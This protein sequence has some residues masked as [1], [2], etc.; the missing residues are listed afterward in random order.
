MALTFWLCGRL[1]DSKHLH[2]RRPR[3]VELSA[4]TVLVVAHPE[5][6][7]SVV[8]HHAATRLAEVGG[9]LTTARS[10]V[11]DEQPP[12]LRGRSPKGHVHSKPAVRRLHG[13]FP[14]SKRDHAIAGEAR[15]H[16]VPRRDP[17]LQ[18]H[19][20]QAAGRVC[21]A[22]HRVVRVSV[23]RIGRVT[24]DRVLGQAGL[25]VDDVAVT[26]SPTDHPPSGATRRDLLLRGLATTP[27]RTAL[28]PDR[29]GGKDATATMATRHLM[30]TSIRVAVPRLDPDRRA[31][32][33]SLGPRGERTVLGS[34]AAHLL[35]GGGAAT[36]L[37]QQLG[38]AEL[39]STPIHARALSARQRDGDGVGPRSF[40]ECR[41]SADRFHRRRVVLVAVTRFTW[42]K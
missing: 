40:G 28:A 26:C 13:L 32:F 31:E 17:A 38:R 19:P 25:G 41:L 11:G 14:C 12:R 8:E 9:R 33:Q 42:R 35:Q 20:L 21:V 7:A 24:T 22:H 39:A 30:Q 1:A 29:S 10:H 3:E 2:L 5:G 4:E 15:L 6:P 36:D 37:W 34:S 23:V 18:G 27:S 16:D